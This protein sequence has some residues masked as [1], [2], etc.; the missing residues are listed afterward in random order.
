[1]PTNAASTTSAL[2]ASLLLTTPAVASTIATSPLYQVSPNL[3]ECI[4][5]NPGTTDVRVGSLELVNQNGSILSQATEFT[6]P[7]GR[8]TFVT[9]NGG[10]ITYCRVTGVSAKKVRLTHC[11]RQTNSGTPCVSVSQGE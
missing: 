11:V 3:N 4:L 2:F 7:A 5:S 10:G 6:I 1:M 8:I 9:T